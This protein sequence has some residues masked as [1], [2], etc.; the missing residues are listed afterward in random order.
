MNHV[1]VDQILE[2]YAWSH[3]K[4]IQSLRKTRLEN[5]KS[6]ERDDCEFVINRKNLTWINEEPQYTNFTPTGSKPYTLF[7]SVYTNNTNR[8]QEYS[9]KT[10]RT[11]ESICSIAR[12]QGYTT[13]AEA[14]L[15]L[16]TPCEIAE[17]KAG[18]KHEM[19]F[20]NLNENC[21]TEILT[22]GVDSNVQVPPHYSTEASII[23]EEM[24]YRGSYSI[25][26]KLSG[27]VTISIKRR[28]DDAL[29]LP[30]RVNIVEVF[31]S[32]LDSPHCRKEVKQVV[33][34]DQR[35]VVRLLSKGTCHFQFAMKQ[36]IDLKENP[37]K[38]GNEIMID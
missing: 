12:E 16:K 2:D 30:I 32:H 1:D 10:E 7:K 3:F 24:N 20:N 33:S 15:T 11:T 25:T 8:P 14:E 31:M 34:I 35:K 37:I 28:K 22:W 38:V 4:D 36:R 27:N 23:I 9:F 21:Q 18:F 29:M 5:F 6:V 17:L 26:T 19:H 13:G